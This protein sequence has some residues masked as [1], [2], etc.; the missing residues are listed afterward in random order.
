MLIGGIEMQNMQTIGIES[1]SQLGPVVSS[2]TVAEEINRRHTHVL[3][4]FRKN[5]TQPKCG[6]SNYS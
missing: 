6:F 1:N 2:R 5:T 4:R 3:E